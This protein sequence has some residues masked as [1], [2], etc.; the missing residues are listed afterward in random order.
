MSSEGNARRLEAIHQR[1][2][3]LSTADALASGE[4]VEDLRVALE[5]LRVAEEELRQQNDALAS[6]QV[7][8]DIERRRYQE[9]FELA[10]DALLRDRPRRHRAPGESLGCP[11]ISGGFRVPAG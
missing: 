1:I 10:P 3:G 7:A 5:E 4:T 11:G 2:N 6:T 8:L 9:L